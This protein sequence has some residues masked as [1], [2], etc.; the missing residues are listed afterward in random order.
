MYASFVSQACVLDDIGQPN[1]LIGIRNNHIPRRMPFI[2]HASRLSVFYAV[3][4]DCGVVII[5]IKLAG[6]DF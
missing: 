5:G 3:E 2:R 1:A 6:D 4:N